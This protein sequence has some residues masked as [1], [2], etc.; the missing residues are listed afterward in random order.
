MPPRST[1]KQHNGM[2]IELQGRIERITHTGDSRA[3]YIG[4]SLKPLRLIHKKETCAM[5]SIRREGKEYE[6]RRLR[7]WQEQDKTAAK[8]SKKEIESESKDKAAVKVPPVR[9]NKIGRNEPCPC[10]SGKKYKKCCLLKEEALQG[11]P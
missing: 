6:E 3:V 8:G 2:L 7:R 5:S 4:K 1:E 11:E 10:G 9:S